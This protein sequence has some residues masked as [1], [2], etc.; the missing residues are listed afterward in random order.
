MENNSRSD[1]VM[2]TTAARRFICIYGL[3]PACGVRWTDDSLYV[4]RNASGWVLSE[5]VF[6]NDIRH[7]LDSLP[8][9]L[10][11]L[12]SGRREIKKLPKTR[13]APAPARRRRRVLPDVG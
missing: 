3:V 13:T 10:T 8:R 5:S 11:K 12:G 2:A 1:Q 4:G 9:P 7:G 6:I